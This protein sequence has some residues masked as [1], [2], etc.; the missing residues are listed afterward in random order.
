MAGN[1][2][3]E[4]GKKGGRPKGSK[5]PETRKKE[6]VLAA[7]RG[8]VMASADKHFQCPDAPRPGG[9]PFIMRR[10]TRLAEL[11]WDQLMP[12]LQVE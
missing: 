6:A 12:W 11:A 1:T 2:S 9:L 3:R 4:N 8:R 5:S 7:F 10:S